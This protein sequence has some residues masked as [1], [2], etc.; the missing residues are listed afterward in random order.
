M[1]NRPRIIPVLLIDYR[2]LIKTKQFGERTY[3]GDPVNAVKI[4]NIKGVDEL[5]ILDIGATKNHKEPDFELL[6][7]I[8]SEAFMPLSYGG[9]IANIDQI[10]K[11]FA[12]GYEK[13][14]IN[15]ALVD[16]PDLIKEAAALFGSQS[17]VVSID[18]KRTTSGY[19]AYV[20][21]GTRKTGQNPVDLAKKALKLGGGEIIINSI[22]NDGM[23]QGYDIELVRSIADSVDIPVTA[24][25]GAGDIRDIKKVLIEGHAHAAAGGS[26]FVFYGRLRAVLITAPR[27]HELVRTGI[28]DE[29]I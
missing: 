17:I 13:V 22:D 10:R 11:L 2:D 1:Y 28:Y 16:N 4:F 15:T 8:A 25:G 18:A 27:E 5:S 6:A 23:M 3:L 9:G 29:L 26:V 12:I 24:I 7:D 21:D 20:E 14:V 19:E